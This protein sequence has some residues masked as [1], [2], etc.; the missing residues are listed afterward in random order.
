MPGPRVAFRAFFP[1]LFSRLLLLRF[2][3]GAEAV[4]LHLQLRRESLRERFRQVLGLEDLTQLKLGVLERRFLEPLDRLFLRIHLPDPV[5]GQELLRLRERT[6]RDRRSAAV[7]LDAA[8]LG[9]RVEALARHHDARV[10]ELFVVLAHLG[11]DLVVRHHAV[12][13]I[14]ISLDQNHESHRVSPCS[15]FGGL[16]TPPGFS[17]L[18]PRRTQRPQ[19]DSVPLPRLRESLNGTPYR[20]VSK[21]GGCCSASAP[22]SRSSYPSP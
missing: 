18:L 3:F 7:E 12:L 11:K 1:W 2:E 6:I 14:L 19:I 17:P 5:P 21:A 15:D 13:G 20:S 16:F 9:C 4:F 8:S 10:D 22:G